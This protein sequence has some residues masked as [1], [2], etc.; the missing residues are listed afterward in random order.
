MLP[1]P[2]AEQ[3]VHE[4]LPDEGHAREVQDDAVEPLEPDR[5]PLRLAAAD[6]LAVEGDEPDLRISGDSVEHERV[7]AGRRG[8]RPALSLAPRVSCNHMSVAATAKQ[9]PCDHSITDG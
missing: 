5:E 9:L 2:H 1:L 4:S 6:E 8:I 3:L 7:R